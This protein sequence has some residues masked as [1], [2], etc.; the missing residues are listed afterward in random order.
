MGG[1]VSQEFWLGLRR[2]G[3]V[4]G[5]VDVGGWRRCLGGLSSACASVEGGSEGEFDVEIEVGSTHMDSLSALRLLH[6]VADVPGRCRGQVV[7]GTGCGSVDM[8]VA[9]Q[10]SVQIVSR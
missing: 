8:D 10:V 5:G 1:L 7:H 4:L 2:G 9:L 3:L 6:M